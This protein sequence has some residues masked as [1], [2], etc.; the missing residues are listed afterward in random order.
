MQQNIEMGQPEHEKMMKFV[1]LLASIEAAGGEL[2]E[3]QKAILERCRENGILPKKEPS[4][5][6][7]TKDDL[8]KAGFELIIDNPGIERAEWAQAMID[9]NAEIIDDV[10]G[11]DM[12][13]LAFLED[14]WDCDDYEDPATGI[15]LRM[16]DWASFFFES[17][18]VE[19]YTELRRKIVSLV[20][21]PQSDT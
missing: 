15:C 2:N 16:S 19:V 18:A 3:Q 17:L 8:L 6:M 7:F 4:T 14:I 1:L 11:L 5:Y 13:T 10:Y 9:C 12:D 20:T 21:S